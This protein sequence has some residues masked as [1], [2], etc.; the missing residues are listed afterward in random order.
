MPCLGW[1][2]ILALIFVE[3]M[4]L[5]ASSGGGLQLILDR[6]AV[7][8][9]VAISTFKSETMVLSHKKSGVPT[10]IQGWWAQKDFQTRILD[11]YNL[12]P[13]PLG[14]AE[15]ESVGGLVSPL[16]LSCKH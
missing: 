2:R 7:K 11:F 12:V 14:Q 8:R 9:E 10:L 1:I 15:L 4:V 5:Y 13:L 3:D 6:F 16:S